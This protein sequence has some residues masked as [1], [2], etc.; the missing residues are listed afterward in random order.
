MAGDS[1]AQPGR[2]SPRLRSPRV[3]AAGAARPG[4]V[5]PTVSDASGSGQRPGSAGFVMTWM[6]CR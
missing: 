1:A 3:R 6:S 4:R 2:L 5:Q